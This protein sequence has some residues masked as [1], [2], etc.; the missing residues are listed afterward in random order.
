V[1]I[2]S[3]PAAG[4]PLCEYVTDMAGT[5]DDGGNFGTISLAL[6]ETEHEGEE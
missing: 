5:V 1:I 6:V 3:G 4:S 2:P